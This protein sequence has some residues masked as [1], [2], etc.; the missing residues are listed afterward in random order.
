MTMQNTG[1]RGLGCCAECAAAERR[2]AS[3]L[4][5]YEQ[6]DLTK[7]E[8]I[9]NPPPVDAPI[10]PQWAELRRIMGGTA[11]VPSSPAERMFPQTQEAAA[12]RAA[13]KQA[14]MEKTLTYAAIGGGALLLVILFVGGRR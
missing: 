10:D 4:G 13:E 12:L 1:C 3:G 5:R 2:A 7:Y 11:I 8:Y 14:A 9:Y 6:F